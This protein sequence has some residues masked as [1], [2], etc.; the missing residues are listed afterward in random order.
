MTAKV[1]LKT[2]RL[3]LRPFKSEDLD[4]VYAY[5]RDPEW[6]RYIG[7][8]LPL[9][10]TR[11]DDSLVLEGIITT[12]SS[13]GHVNIAPMGPIVDPHTQFMVLR[14]F[15]TSTT[16][17]NLKATG[18]GVFHITDDVLL[19]ARA[20]IGEVQPS[21]HVPVRNAERV[22]GLILAD[23][24]RYYELQVASLD[25]LEHRVTIEVRV[26]A[27]FEWKDLRTGRI[28]RQQSGRL[29]AAAYGPARQIGESQALGLLVSMM[30]LGSLVGAL[31]IASLGHWRR[32]ALI[33]GG[34]FVTAFAMML[35]AMTLAP[36]RP[37]CGQMARGPCWGTPRPLQV[38]ALSGATRLPVRLLPMMVSKRVRRTLT[39]LRS[40]IALQA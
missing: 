24:C 6:E 9:P 10:Y 5:T 31:T 29:I 37:L 3:L 17:K 36:T 40:A 2:E 33:I 11:P 19:M 25:D 39:P 8:P 15:K 21:E 34:G 13:E 38:L 30:G 20:A 26:V 22:T 12:L 35:M 23:A 14:P 4:D 16:Y 1:E 27:D 32:G 28:L 7:P 18:E